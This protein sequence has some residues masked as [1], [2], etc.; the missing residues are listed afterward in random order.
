[1]LIKDKRL[2]EERMKMRKEMDEDGWRNSKK[3][4]GPFELPRK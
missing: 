1:M 4:F 2:G 3:S